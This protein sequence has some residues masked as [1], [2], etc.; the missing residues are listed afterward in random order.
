MLRPLRD[1]I[2]VKPV[3][4]QISDI[5]HVQNREKF[6]RGTI[7]AVGPKV[8]DAQVGDFVVYGNGTYLEWPTHQIDGQDYQL[9]QEADICMVMEAQ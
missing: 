4:R 2:V 6:N 8:K 3:I 5:I 7:V 9:I 1:R